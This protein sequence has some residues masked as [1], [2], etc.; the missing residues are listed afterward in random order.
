MILIP[1]FKLSFELIKFD[2]LGFSFLSIYIL[3]YFSHFLFSL[4]FLDDF[5]LS[6]PLGLALEIRQRTLRSALLLFETTK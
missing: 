2:H 6:S 5:V 3:Q 4:T 1:E